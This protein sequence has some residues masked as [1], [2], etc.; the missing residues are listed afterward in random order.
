MDI[1]T[2]GVGAGIFTINEARAT[3]GLGELEEVPAAE[4][5]EPEEPAETET[6]DVEMEAE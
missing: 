6:P 2:A 1:A 5:V 3:L 4:A